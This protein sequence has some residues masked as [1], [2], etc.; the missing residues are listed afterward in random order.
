MRHFGLPFKL[1]NMNFVATFYGS[2]VKRGEE[3]NQRQAL[4]CTC[5]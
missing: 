5:Q 3:L 2:A 1:M 4:D